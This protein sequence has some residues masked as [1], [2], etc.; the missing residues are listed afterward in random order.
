V[1]AGA[2][3]PPYC[4][5]VSACRTCGE[6]NPARARFCWNCG[7]SLE[8]PE[9]REVRKTVTLLFT[10][11]T[12][13][14]E[15]GEG[16]DA[17]SIRGVMNRYFSEMRRVIERHGGTVEKFV[18][19]AV[20][21]AFGIPRVHE[22][23]AL[24]AVR[25]AQ[26]MRESLRALNDELQKDWGVRIAVRTGVNTGEVVAGDASTRETFATGDTVNTAARLEQA[27]SPWEIL[28]GESTYRLVRG[29]VRAEP[30]DALT[31]KGK[32]E[33]I[34]A[35]RLME[36]TAP[37]PAPDRATGAPWV[38]REAEL[39][40]LH[41]AF[42]EAN[43]G[44]T[45]R[46]VLVLGEAGVGK[47][48]LVAEFLAEVGPEV[49]ALR[50]RCL[51]YGDGI[52][53]WP[54]VEVLK[55]AASIDESDSP[56]DSRRKLSTLVEREDRSAIVAERVGA[57]MG[58]AE[59]AGTIEETFWATRIV[60]EAVARVR[61]AV[62]VVEDLHWAEPT[63]LDLIAHLAD[64]AK[65]VPLLIVGTAR[66]E[67]LEGPPGLGGEARWEHQ[68]PTGGPVGGRDPAPDRG[69]PWSVQAPR[70]AEGPGH[71]GGRR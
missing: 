24:R 53:F 25:A 37:G 39:G 61:P 58:L 70:R 35:Y 54:V 15:L 57:L 42:Q 22:D 69:G 4:S 44:Q 2:F 40:L 55:Q 21:A 65:D 64:Y 31:L 1:H 10:D 28:L 26:E 49:T 9:P 48:R 33:P 59:S 34:P 63:L 62:V 11:V 67:L 51:S 17:E 3:L 43:G 66:P 23:D 36:L 32:A 47:S 38:G 6:R 52:T 41:Q 29:L 56:Y 7:S 46:L 50:G 8:T 14:T 16:R 20:M 13:S 5:I 27:A 60:L 19:D 45:C 18:G 30:V 71:P 12:G 68:D